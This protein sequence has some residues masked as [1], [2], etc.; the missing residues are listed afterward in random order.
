[1]T[2]ED[3]RVRAGSAEAERPPERTAP[4][5]E[6]LRFALRQGPL[7]GLLQ[8]PVRV[9]ERIA[10]TAVLPPRHARGARGRALPVGTR[11]LLA[12]ADY[13]HGRVRREER[14]EGEPADGETVGYALTA[15]FGLQRREPSN[16]ANDHRAV[17]SVRS[18]FPVHVLAVGPWG[19]A[20]YLDLYRHALV[21]VDVEPA[22]LTGL[23]PSTGEVRIVLAARYTDFPT[24]YGILRR[25]LGDLEVGINLRALVV[26]ARLFGLRATVQHSGPEAA[27]AA[28][29]LA[30]TGPGAWSPPV[31]VTLHGAGVLAES[32]PLGPVH[33][34]RY[35]PRGDVLLEAES[36]HPTLT[37]S[38]ASVEARR[39]AGEEPPVPAEAIPVRPAPVAGPPLD[40]GRVLWNRTAGRVP[41][42][43][44]GFSVR[45]SRTDRRRVEELLAWAEVP[46]PAG[47]L[48]EVRSSVGL[49]AVVQHTD[50]LVAG[51]YSVTAEG[52]LRL[53]RAD[54]RLAAGL[55]TGFGYPLTA[56]ND[57]G[58][59]HASSIWVCTA[60]PERLLADHGPAAWSLL[61]VACGW[62]AHGLTMA[63]AAQGLF[64][65][66]ARS[67]DEHL[68]TG[69]LRLPR[70]Q[71]PV[72]MVVCGRARYAE[73]MLDLRV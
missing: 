35:G 62:T 70:E 22:V 4:A 39:S 21:D 43:Q 23:R 6:V 40:W 19:A 31:V 34:E 24:A 56:G 45:P 36:R 15:A 1:V 73:P 69:L 61:Q 72:L 17:A 71:W 57:C 64:A 16:P 28:R 58:L 54:P 27:A 26:A 60:D 10:T 52:A 20:G 12:G 53:E 66:P 7:R 63:A 33:P 42:A 13:P 49:H 68:V 5:D 50:G 8:E 44:T 67:F 25:A 11:D 37:G 46:A 32:R 38:A 14:A 55:E 3:I 65:R 9:D 47:L 51:H 48:R 18:K 41:A 59:R 2:A 30:A 29:L